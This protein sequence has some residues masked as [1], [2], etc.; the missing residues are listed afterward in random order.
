[1]NTSSS[2]SQ[3]SSPEF[4]IGISPSNRIFETPIPSDT[5][6]LLVASVMNDNF[7]L[8]QKNIL[9]IE[10]QLS[11]LKKSYVDCELSASTSK[12]DVFSDSIK[13]F[14]QISRIKNTK[15]V[16][17]KFLRKILHFYRMK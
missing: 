16:K 14:S 4:T 3:K 1:M 17:L 15:R 5:H 13:T 12:I 6:F 8:T 9:K 7:R 2:I 11:V 10:P